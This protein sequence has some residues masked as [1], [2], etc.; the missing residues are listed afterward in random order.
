MLA[1]L[2]KSNVVAG[3]CEVLWVANECGVTGEV[4]P[5]AMKGALGMLADLDEMGLLDE[6]DADAMAQTL[7]ILAEQAAAA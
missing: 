4:D 6:K 3:V 7:E 1:A 5:K 2:T